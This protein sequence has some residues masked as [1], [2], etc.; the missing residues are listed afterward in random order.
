MVSPNEVRTLP[1]KPGVYRFFNQ[2]EALIYV[3]KAKDIKKRVSSYFNKTINT[4]RKT[5]KMVS[6]IVGIEYTVVNTEFDALLLENNLIKTNQPRYNILLKDDK[7][8]PFISIRKERFPRITST[9]RVNLKTGEYLGPYANVRAM[10]AVLGLLKNLYHI[11]TCNYNLSKENIE[12]GKFKV[13]LEYHLG[14]CL[15]PCEGLQSEKDYVHEIKEARSILKGN[16]SFVKRSF[17]KNMEEAA[18]NL[19]F[20]AAQKHKEKLELLDK[21]QSRTMITNPKIK[22]TDVIGIVSDE[23]YAFI[24]YLKIHN[25]T[26]LNTESVEV[27]K[28]LDESDEE[29]LVYATLELREKYSSQAT[30]IISNKPFTIGEIE[31]FV[32][33]RGDKKQLVDLSIKN[34]LFYKK[35]KYTQPEI[36]KDR[37]ERILGELKEVLQLREKPMHIECFDNSNIQ[38]THPVASMVC[39]INAKPAKKEYR[40]YNIKTVEGPDDFASMYEINYRRYN[41]LIDEGKPLPNLII[42]DGGKGQLNAACNAL[43][44]LDIYGKV[45]IIGIAKKLEEIYIPGDP[46]PLHIDKKSEALKLIQQMRDEA[47][48][49]AITFHRQKRSNASLNT[50]L[51]HVPGIGEKTINQLLDQYKS[52]KKIRE[53]SKEEII[54]LIGKSKAQKLWAYYERT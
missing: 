30:T 41:R 6:E 27:K 3:G 44:D 40:H 10:N 34:A 50:E 20:E 35:E 13:C 2:E 12:A 19:Q 14:N 11:R 8:F 29:I 28:K 31:S 49:F 45:P 51:N 7:S 17:K 48:R 5:R 53:A 32:P 18:S 37:G 24:N 52:A 42:V 16:I 4:N 38:G 36:R 21:F 47:H 1:G 33:Q 46:Y 23:K 26:I 39:F 54:H 25:G 15:G 43:R 22:D 9:R